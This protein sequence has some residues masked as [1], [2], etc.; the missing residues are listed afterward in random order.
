LF[1]EL[2]TNLSLRVEE[3]D[4]PDTFKV[5]G[6]GELQLAILI[7]TMRRQG[8]EFMVSRPTVIYKEINGHTYE[9]IEHLVIDVPEDFLGVVMEKLGVRKAEMTNMTSS[10]QGYMRLEFRIPVRGLIGYRSEFLTDTKGNGILNHIFHG[11]EPIKG[12][13]P[14]RSRGSLIAFEAG[15]AVTYG[16]YNTQERGE[17]FIEPGTAVYEGMVV[18]ENARAEDIVV[19]VC[20]KKHVTNMRASGSDEALRLTPVRKMSLEQYLEFISDD[21]LVE[22]TPKNIR[23]RKKI[24]DSEKRAKARAKE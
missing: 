20:K 18:G 11:Y 3:T 19:N 24:L 23:I 14:V 15:E 7:E 8:Y 2:E 9:P 1:K 16:L 21:E 13:I 4:S 5:S 17:L 12:D 6:R 10:S 22:V